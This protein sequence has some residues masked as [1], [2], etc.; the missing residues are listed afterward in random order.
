MKRPL[1]VFLV[2]VISGLMSLAERAP[3]VIDSWSILVLIEK[4][5]DNLPKV[6]VIKNEGEWAIQQEQIEQ[7]KIQ[8]AKE[9][10]QLDQ[11]AII[12]S[13][14]FVNGKKLSKTNKVTNEFARDLRRLLRSFENFPQ[15][16]N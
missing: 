1:A 5:V 12:Y 11:E 2:I 7:F 8:F 3:S 13:A 10:S 4:G 14:S 16:V 9:V 15:V 6:T